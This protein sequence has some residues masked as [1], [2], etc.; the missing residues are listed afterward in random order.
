M[1]H[2]Q[3][4]VYIYSKIKSYSFKYENSKLMQACIIIIILCNPLHPSNYSIPRHSATSV[5]RQLQDRHAAAH[6]RGSPA[7]SKGHVRTWG[8]GVWPAADHWCSPWW[9]LKIGV[10]ASMVYHGLESVYILVI[11][12]H[13]MPNS[14]HLLQTLATYHEFLRWE[15]ELKILQNNVTAVNRC[16]QWHRQAD[17]IDK[18]R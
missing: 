6:G 1:I 9:L 4:H 5:T 8:V 15:W 10:P 14:H 13:L 12:R 18:Y 16:K 2:T 7:H 11:C 17:K 3:S